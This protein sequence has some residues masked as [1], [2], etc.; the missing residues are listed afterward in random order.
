LTAGAQTT[1]GRAYPPWGLAIAALALT[2]R[3]SF[4]RKRHWPRKK[5]HL[6]A[7]WTLVDLFYEGLKRVMRSYYASLTSAAVLSTMLIT[8]GSEID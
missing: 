1:G 6:L 3:C 5:D 8:W 2:P 7:V 4:Y